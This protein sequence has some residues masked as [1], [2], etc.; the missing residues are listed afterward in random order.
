MEIS[1]L[2]QPVRGWNNQVCVF[3]LATSRWRNPCCRG[4]VPSPRAA[5]TAARVGHHVY[6]FGGRHCNKRLND[7]YQLNLHTLTWTWSVLS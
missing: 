3:D 4:A 1:P 2:Q 5:H 7:L 6:V